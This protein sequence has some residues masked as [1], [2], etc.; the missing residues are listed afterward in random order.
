MGQG[1]EKESLFGKLINIITG[2][3]SPPKKP[4]ENKVEGKYS[5]KV[6]EPL[7]LRF[8]KNFTKSGGNFLY[9]KNLQEVKDVISKICVEENIAHIF[10]NEDEMKHILEGGSAQVSS[11]AKRSN[12]ICSTCEAMIAN[13]GGIMIDDLQ[14]GSI[15]LSDLPEVHII[16]GKTSQIVEG[17]HAGM[18]AINKKY[19]KNIPGQLTTLK[20]HK[21]ESV[22][23][24][25]N[26]SNAKRTLFL[27]LLEDEIG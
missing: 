11:D 26:D 3:P 16:L 8:V 10:T 24:A 15:R 14:T 9:C 21:D 13:M 27:L 23:Q 19:N 7:D 1:Q 25:S 18:A 22:K 2:N 5:P 12:A 6:E 20:G 4:A 17:L